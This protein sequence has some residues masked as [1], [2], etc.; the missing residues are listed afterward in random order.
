MAAA[1]VKAGFHLDLTNPKDGRKVRGWCI[2]FNIGVRRQDLT[3]EDL[4]AGIAAVEDSVRR[5]AADTAVQ[6]FVCQLEQAP[7][8]GMLHVQGF[9][10][11]QHARRLSTVK[12]WCAVVN[13]NGAHLEPM[14]GTPQQAWDYCTKDESRVAGPYLHG[15]RPGGQGDRRDLKTFVADAAKL[16]TREL[17]LADLQE[18][19]YSVEA[20]HTKY[21]DR[22]VGRNQ[23]GRDFPTFCGVFYGDSGTGKSRMARQFCADHKLGDP[24]FLR[25]PETKTAQLF[26]ERYR[27]EPVVIVDEM[28]PNRMTLAEFNSLIDSRP[29]LVNVKG[30]S[31]QFLSRLIIFTSNFHPDLWFVPKDD[32][33]RLRQTVRR[34]INWLIE[35]SYHAD[36]RPDRTFSN[37][38]EV[39]ENAERV[40]KKDDSLIAQWAE[41]FHANRG[42][43]LPSV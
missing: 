37:D 22:V 2:T 21:F 15:D 8:T 18:T 20:R 41:D 36:H 14:R 25:L 5:I 3:D 6:R 4:K 32:D 13:F 28:G 31:E 39:Y 35:F 30:S 10:H 38:R 11:F 29:H 9:V 40:I 12:H 16:K 27:Q 26:W 19:H 17:T 34:R 43:A 42:A 7:D 33:D 23:S 24:Y 1:D